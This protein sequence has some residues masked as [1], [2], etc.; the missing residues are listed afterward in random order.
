MAESSRNIHINNIPGAPTPQNT[1]ASISSFIQRASDGKPNVSTIN[2]EE[3]AVTGLRNNLALMSIIEGKLGNLVGDSSEKLVA[4]LPL[5]VRNRVRGLRAV[6]AEQILLEIE[7]EGEI[8]ALEKK[9]QT[10]YA[11]LYEKR[12]NI[13][14]GTEEPTPEQI[15]EGKDIEK[16]E[17][18]DEDLEEEKPRLVE[19]TEDDE[20]NDDPEASATKESIK[21]IPDFWVTAL[22]NESLLSTLIFERD[23][24][25]LHYLTDIR[26]ECLHLTGYQLT[27]VFAENPFFYN[28]QLTKTF[29]APGPDSEDITST[30]RVSHSEGDKI[31]WKSPEQNLTLTIEKR[32]QRNKHTKETRIIERRIPNQS[33]FTFFNGVKAPANSA[34]DKVEN[35][36][37]GEEEEELFVSGLET[38]I[39]IG[40]SIKDLIATAVDWYTG[41]ALRGENEFESE[42]DYEVGDYEAASDDDDED[43]EDVYDEDS[44]S[45]VKAGNVGGQDSSECKQ[46]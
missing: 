37:E 8:L 41:I 33:F 20:T 23:E 7:L 46:Q 32:K 42:D 43:D 9:W 34:N 12:A 44:K 13:V 40:E 17:Q 45:Q 19:I 10:K 29:I 38:D 31:E 24:E 28:K 36:E 21:G 22:K 39:A 5:P 11:P 27:F 18:D 26:I 15:Q 3:T 2:E 30:F 16:E 25:A 6:Q 4:N 1:P 35:D 14:N